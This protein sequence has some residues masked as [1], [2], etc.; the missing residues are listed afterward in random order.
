MG[1]PITDMQHMPEADFRWL[2]AHAQE[3]GTPWRRVEALLTRL[4]WLVGRQQPDLSQDPAAYA[5]DAPA[6][7]LAAEPTDPPLPADFKPV[8]LRKR[9]P[10]T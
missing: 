5:L 3:H 4:C 10:P 1:L 7:P 9:P 6:P 8:N 2:V